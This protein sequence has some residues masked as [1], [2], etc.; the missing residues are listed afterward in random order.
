MTLNNP[1]PLELKEPGDKRWEC[2]G[3]KGRKGDKEAKCQGSDT[4]LLLKTR[5]SVKV[6]TQGYKQRA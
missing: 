3:E 2:V 1:L 4:D 6:K 5:K